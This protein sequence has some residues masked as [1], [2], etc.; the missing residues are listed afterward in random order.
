M[1]KLL[2][3]F[4]LLLC[5]VASADAQRRPATRAAKTVIFAVLNDG[6]AIEPIG[7]IGAKG[8]MT[9]AVDGASEAAVLN[10][11]HRSYFGAFPVR[12]HSR[13]KP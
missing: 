10:A 6:K 3:F 5:F 12:I 8:V 11:F 7:Y 9:S 13:N 2:L 4:A 1:Q